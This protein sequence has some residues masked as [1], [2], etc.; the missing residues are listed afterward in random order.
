MSELKIEELPTKRILVTA[1]MSAGKSTL[2]NALIG[3]KL[4]ATQHESCTAI[5]WIVKE[6]SEAK[7][8]YGKYQNL[9]IRFKREVSEF[10]HTQETQ[11]LE[12]FVKMDR[13][14]DGHNWELIDTPGINSSLDP[15]HKKMTE[16]ILNEGNFDILLYVLNGS[17]LGVNDDLQHLRHVQRH[18]SLDKIIFVLNKVDQFRSGEDSVGKSINDLMRQ[19]NEL[20]FN[21]PVI[22]PLSAYTAFLIKQQ[23]QQIDLL[24]E[25]E[26]ELELF[27][28]KFKRAEF[29]LSPP[30]LKDVEVKSDARLV[31]CGMYS[32]EQ[33]I[34]G[35]EVTNEQRLHSVQS[36]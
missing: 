35:K 2:I 19:L 3:Q 4:M 27:T 21:N 10:L 9:K 15:E 7:G 30:A 5:P 25:E 22:Q 23:N 20:G 33:L 24:E 28:R 36:V 31:R 8:M 29:D 18:V 32:L 1:T 11:Q 13:L 17:Y 12:I 26:D 6:D 34:N 16:E 14:N